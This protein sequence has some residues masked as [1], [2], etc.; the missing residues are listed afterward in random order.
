MWAGKLG[1]HVVGQVGLG[2]QGSPGAGGVG[3]EARGDM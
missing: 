1:G 2:R 3:G